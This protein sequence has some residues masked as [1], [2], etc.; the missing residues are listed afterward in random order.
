MRHLLCGVITLFLV[1][2]V[3]PGY[4]ADKKDKK[5]APDAKKEDVKKDA[6]NKESPWVRVGQLTGTL[7]DVNESNK[8]IRVRVDVPRLNPQAVLGL[9][10]AQQGVVMAQLA[11]A[12]AAAQ[13]PP[14]RY[15]ALFNAQL[16]M[17]QAQQNVAR[18]QSHLYHKVSQEVEMQT[19]DD[20]V[21]RLIG[22][23]PKFNDKGKRVRPTAKELKEAKGTNPKLP[24]Y[25]AA[26]SDLHHNQVIQVTLARTKNA[27][28]AK[29]VNP[30]NKDADTDLLADAKPHVS[31]IIV[32]ADPTPDR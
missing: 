28:K 24:G 30:K 22:P 3:L 26:F 13:P 25:Q 12:Q 6:D 16:R 9:A 32:L 4:G 5:D 31:M 17:A 18:Q 2:I 15:Q 21:V 11:L 8:G 1:I 20:L 10:Q 7:V 29:P 14:Q 27:P 19:I 23:A